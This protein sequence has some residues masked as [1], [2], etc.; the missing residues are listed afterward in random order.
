MYFIDLSTGEQ[1]LIDITDQF[2]INSELSTLTR[3]KDNFYILKSQEKQSVLLY[4]IH[5]D[6]SIAEPIEI[7]YSE[8]LKQFASKYEVD[9]TLDYVEEDYFYL[10]HEIIDDKLYIYPIEFDTNNQAAYQVSN[11]QNGKL[12]GEGH[13]EISEKNNDSTNYI[14]SGKLIDYVD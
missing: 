4:S 5:D 9:E 8:E 12:L 11:V 14:I 10:S 1:T 13:F 6:G 2:D 3:Y 7:D